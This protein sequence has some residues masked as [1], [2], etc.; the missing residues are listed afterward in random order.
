MTDRPKP[1]GPRRRAPGSSD[2][3]GVALLRR[4]IDASGL[5]DSA[6]AREVLVRDGRT[7]RGWLYGT[8]PIPKVVL[9]K[10]RAL[11]GE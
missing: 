6:F 11:V 1:T 8:A 5:S 9:D 2:P 4:A 7:V 3:A 10:L